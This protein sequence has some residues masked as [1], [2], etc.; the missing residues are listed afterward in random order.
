VGELSLAANGVNNNAGYV[1]VTGA[2]LSGS[3][4]RGAHISNG[5]KL[6]ATNANVDN[7][8]GIGL[9]VDS[10]AEVVASGATVKNSGGNAIWC[11]KGGKVV[12][13]DGDCSGAVGNPAIRAHLGGNVE[14]SGANA[15]RGLEPDSSDIRSSSGSIIN[16]VGATGGTYSTPNTLTVD[17]VIFK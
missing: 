16:A 17:G 4:N 14:M 15:Q 9:Y 1:D 12:I 10:G 11:Q 7:S 2:N 13:T 8:V 5:G 6:I 3:Q